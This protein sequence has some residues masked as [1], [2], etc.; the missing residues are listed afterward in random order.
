MRDLF[1]RIEEIQEKAEMKCPIKVWER[2]N[3]F[4]TNTFFS[5]SIAIRIGSRKL[6]VASI[7]RVLT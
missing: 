3:N 4:D 2:R 6:V 5:G 1:P 7:C